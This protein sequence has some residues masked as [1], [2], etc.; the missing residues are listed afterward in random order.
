M[1]GR[2]VETVGGTAAF[3]IFTLLPVGWLYW[4]WTAIQLGSFGMFVMG[5][6]PPLAIVTAPIGLYALVFG[7]PSWVVSLFG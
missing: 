1:I 5:V 3:L 2:A 6:I 4:V 7:V